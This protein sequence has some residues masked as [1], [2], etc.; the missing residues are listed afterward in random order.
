MSRARWPFLGAALLMLFGAVAS[1]AAQQA[2][3]AAGPELRISTKSTTFRQGE[4]IPIQLSFTS[5]LPNRYQINL[6]TY[7]RS[8]RMSYEQFV[9][10]PAEGTEDPLLLYFDS[11]GGFMG[12]GITTFK[13]L[14][15]V[16]IE[17][18]LNLNEWVT[19]EK[20]GNY[21]LKVVSRR[22][23][24]TRAGGDPYANIVDLESNTID[25][26]IVPASPAWQRA[27]LAK[28]IAA[29]NEGRRSENYTRGE[30][31]WKALTALRYLGSEAAARELARRLRGE[32]N[33][34][35]FNCMAGL[36]GSPKRAAGTEEM[37]NLLDD[38]A[39]P[40]S[41]MFLEAMAIIPL[42]PSSPP[43]SLQQQRKKNLAALYQRLVS[44]VVN[45]QGKALAVSVDT[46][47]SGSSTILPSEQM[48][49]LMPQFIRSFRM[50]PPAEQAFWLQDRW[51]EIK[52]PSWIPFLRETAL[53]YQN[54][55]ELRVTP[56]YESLQVSGAALLR[57]YEL[58]PTEARDAVLAEITR[59]KPRY[60]A[61]ILGILPDKTL[62]GAS[63]IIAQNFL[64]TD[65]YEI[66]G[67]LASLLFRY[68]DASVMPEVLAK[69]GEL[70]GDWACEPQDKT[71]AYVLKFDPADA[72]PL[73]ERAI[74]ARGPGQSA[75][76]HMVFT[77]IGKL[78]SS[79]VLEELAV[80]SLNDPD[81]QVAMD[82]AAYLGEH[83]SATAEQALWTRYEQWNQTWAGRESELR[84]VFGRQSPHAWDAGLGEAL[85]RA[86]ATGVGWLADQSV[87][88]RIQEFAVGKNM[89]AEIGRDLQ[90]WSAG[91]LAMNFIPSVPPSFSVAQ[92]NFDSMDALKTK[93][94]EFPRGTR[95]FLPP[96]SPGASPD[97]LAA[98]K[99]MIE[100]AT[101][102]GLVVTRTPESSPP[103]E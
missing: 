32:N 42:D 89:R 10:H 88:S 46:L 71:L 3:S 9:I 28:I 23:D 21:E 16:P 39:F 20:P 83:G 38:P 6:A 76:N 94:K 75:C 55:P 47:M 36:I 59:P 51:N 4:A 19:F 52:D 102:D 14:S 15:S 91:T 18:S 98:I 97:E 63:Q 96:A 5:P 50:L 68:A 95:L 7:D 35:D 92:Y 85:G 30:S 103:V 58:D 2:K 22:V 11:I 69:A 78:Q 72:R 86:L 31:Y 27:Q 62:P 57:W 33:N 8:G 66:E 13:F 93:L 1:A 80:A 67:N 81:P 82:A 101:K 74:E 45:K 26:R 99:Q 84:F 79:P 40:V 41:P 70:V 90:L 87:L 100:I 56:A 48:R 65:D 17:V 24:D 12:G 44:A 43:S 37:N 64:S 73:I 60:N 29:L 34:T 54:F 77:G 61:S 49:Q 53:H 25:L